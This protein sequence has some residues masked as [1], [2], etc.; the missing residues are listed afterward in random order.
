M[1]Q[2]ILGVVTKLI[3]TDEITRFDGTCLCT[4]SILK[5]LKLLGEGIIVFISGAEISVIK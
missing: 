4:V 2:I 3:H 5:T 1:P